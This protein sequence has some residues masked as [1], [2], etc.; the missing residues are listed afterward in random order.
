MLVMGK[1]HLS[2]A[3]FARWLVNHREAE[4]S[5]DMREHLISESYAA[6]ESGLTLLG[7]ALSTVPCSHKLNIVGQAIR[8]IHANPTFFV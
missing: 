5:H 3:E 7:E 8:V 1:R 4:L 6:L 2:E